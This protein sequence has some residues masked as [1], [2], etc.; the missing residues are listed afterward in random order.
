[1]ASLTR[2]KAVGKLKPSSTVLM[3]CDIQERFKSV[4]HEWDKMVTVSKTMIDAANI[5]QMP[6]VVS[7][8]YP[9]AFLHTVNEIQSSFDKSTKIFEKKKFSMLTEDCKK[10]LQSFETEKK[11]AI[12]VGIEAHVCILQTSLDLAELGYEVHV[13]ADGVSSQNPD[14]HRHAMDRLRQSGIYV[15]TS[16]SILFQLCETAEYEHFRSISSLVKNQAEALK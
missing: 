1:M 6:V 11:T 9:K 14:H 13:L 4:I 12:V 10:H 7:E 2:L 16:E 5:M 15:T 3:V 8:Q